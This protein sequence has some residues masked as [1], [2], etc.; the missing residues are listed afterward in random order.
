MPGMS[1]VPDTE[2]TETEDAPEG[3]E[4]TETE[5]DGADE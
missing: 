4:E 5:D 2:E 1:D 3:D